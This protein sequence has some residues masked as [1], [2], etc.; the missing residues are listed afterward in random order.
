MPTSR[1]LMFIDAPK[2]YSVNYNYQEFTVEHED[3]VM[4]GLD[5]AMEYVENMVDTDFSDLVNAIKSENYTIA[6]SRNIVE[7]QLGA[8]I[9][10]PV[11]DREETGHEF[12]EL[13]TISIVR[14]SDIES[15]E[16]LLPYSNTYHKIVAGYKQGRS[17]Q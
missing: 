8:Y 2:F 14:E 6:W 12:Y 13:F 5:E 9:S 10:H 17:T 16:K 11:D 7:W 15:M 1:Y 3:T 4:Q